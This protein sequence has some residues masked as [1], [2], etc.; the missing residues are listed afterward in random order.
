MQKMRLSSQTFPP[1]ST[2]LEKGGLDGAITMSI[3]IREIYLIFLSSGGSSP[4]RRLSQPGSWQLL[5][6]FLPEKDTC[7]VVVFCSLA[8][9]Q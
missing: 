7:S 1:S 9:A 8:V 6:L 5:Y 4:P 2:R 3:Y